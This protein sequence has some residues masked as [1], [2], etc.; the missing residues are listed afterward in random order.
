MAVRDKSDAP[1]IFGA[2][3]C[4]LSGQTQGEYVDYTG[5][6]SFEKWHR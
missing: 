1:Q 2:Q 3:L 5:S 4:Q 6:I